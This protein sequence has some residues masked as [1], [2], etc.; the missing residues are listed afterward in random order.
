MVDAQHSLGGQMP[1]GMRHPALGPPIPPYQPPTTRHVNDE[2]E[3]SAPQSRPGV[4]V[5]VVL[6]RHQ[7]VVAHCPGCS[8]V[9]ATPP[10]G[11]GIG[12]IQ[13]LGLVADALLA[14][15][16]RPEGGRGGQRNARAHDPAHGIAHARKPWR[17]LSTSSVSGDD[18]R[19]R[20]RTPWLDR[21]AEFARALAA[22]AR[23]R[24]REVAGVGVVRARA[25]RTASGVRC[26]LVC[27]EVWSA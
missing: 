27:R 11:L 2:P 18:R 25:R 1:T 19:R 9:T 16:G 4:V 12:M 23:E 6:V 17:L 26:S 15:G 5:E 22:M 10:S 24:T 8:A 3:P 13:D 7:R 21:R 14:A 20:P